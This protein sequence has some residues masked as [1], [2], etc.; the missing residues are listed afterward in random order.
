MIPDSQKV[1][2]IRVKLYDFM[3]RDSVDEP[4]LQWACEEFHF[5]LEKVVEHC[6]NPESEDTE[7]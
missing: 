6:L 2:E 7:Q 5:N 1:Q 3:S 4:T